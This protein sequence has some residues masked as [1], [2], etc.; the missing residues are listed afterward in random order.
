MPRSRSSISKARSYKEIGEF[1]DTN[2]LTDY[3]DQTTPVEFEVDIQSEAVYYPIE[4]K[5]YAKISRLAR[6]RGVPAGTL[7]NLWL[8]EKLG[9]ESAAK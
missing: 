9:Q 7:L 8:K 4:P 3:W 2:D 6:K 1:W 5:L